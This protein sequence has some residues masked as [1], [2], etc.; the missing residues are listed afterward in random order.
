MRAGTPRVPRRAASVLAGRAAAAFAAPTLAALADREPGD[1]ERRDRVEP[2]PA[3]ERVP[4]QPGE[5]G[6]G[7][8]AAEDVLGA[9][10][11]RGAGAE[12]VRQLFLRA[13]DIVASAGR[14]RD[15]ASKPGYFVWV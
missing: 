1:Y 11:V 2:P 10:A 9:F 3:E 12:L 15:A 8:V 13:S 14:G 5:H 6:D 7:E 4:E